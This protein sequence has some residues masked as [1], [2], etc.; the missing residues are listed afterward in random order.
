MEHHGFDKEPAAAVNLPAYQA[1]RA[2]NQLRFGDV[3]AAS[4]TNTVIN[5]NNPAARERP[6]TAASAL[7]ADAR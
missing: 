5:V 4:V 3:G 1:A 2:V 6:A 7:I